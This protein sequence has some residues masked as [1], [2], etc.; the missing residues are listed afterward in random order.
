MRKRWKILCG[1]LAGV[2][3]L[4][5]LV[6]AQFRVQPVTSLRIHPDSVSLVPGVS[7]TLQVEGHTE[8]GHSAK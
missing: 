4:G 8:D 1:G 3:L 7:V 5:V 2:V 6:T